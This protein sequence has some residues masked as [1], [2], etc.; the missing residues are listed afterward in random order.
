[1]IE[2]V[3]QILNALSLGGQYAL[4]ALGLAIVSSV[5]GLV[6]FAHGE[7]VTITGFSMLGLQYLGVPPIV[8]LP[9]GIVA[10]TLAAVLTER[11]AFRPVRRAD[12]TTMFLTSFGVSIVIQ[13]LILMFVATRPRAVATPE[14]MRGVIEIGAFRIQ[15][16][17]LLT[18]GMTAVGL[19]VLVVFL[20]RTTVGIAMRA[21]AENFTM[22]RLV[23]INAD[24]LLTASFALS[25]FLAG[26]AAIFIIARRGA[27]DSF[28]GFIPVVKAFVAAVLGGFG[29]LVGA[30]L[31]GFALGFLEVALDAYLPQSAAG[32]R[33]AFVFVLVGAVLVVRPQGLFGRADQVIA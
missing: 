26:I 17:Q 9:L 6:N 21:A 20:Q 16:L 33:D 23:G 14:W 11:V 1:M 25:G 15:V 4:L 10:A 13:N 31:G 22:T 30:T 32:F 19:A 18:T 8:L 27:V 3:Q 7:L 5:M 29:S 12:S 24:R 28:M 2:L